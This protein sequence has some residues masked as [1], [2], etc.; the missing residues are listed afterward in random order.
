MNVTRIQSSADFQSLVGEWSSLQEHAATSIFQTWHW[1]F[2]WWKHYGAG[3]SLYL[4][5][6]RRHDGEL[7]GVLPLYLDR[8]SILPGWGVRVLRMVGTGGDTTPDYLDAIVAP[9]AD[10]PAVFASL[11]SYLREHQREWDCL[12][13]SDLAEDS[14]FASALRKWND[15]PRW[16]WKESM[17]ARISYLTLPGSWDDYLGALGR[18]RRYTIRSLRK[19]F[20]ALAG[21]RFF[22]WEAGR[23]IDAA[24]ARL[25]ALHHAR[26]E[27][28]DE[29][30]A[31]SSDAY[32]GFHLDVMRECHARGW[33]RI[34][35]ME[36]E[37]EIIAMYYCYAWRGTTYYF[38]GGFDPR[39]EKLRPGLSLMGYAIEQ[40]IGEGQQQFDM[41][42]GEYE[43]KKQWAKQERI[44]VTRSCHRPLLSTSLY[45]LRLATVPRVKRS[46]KFVLGRA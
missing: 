3:R 10:Q 42:R 35:C 14:P 28:K 25:A 6:A 21:A 30:H 5:V 1:Q 44:T 22:T 31:F 39:H 12:R 33:L 13:L 4:L 29:D 41:L 40:A 26:W 34:H 38:Q 8:E 45:R 37:N 46:I 23:D 17:A 32:N 20:L 36:L 24:F 16:A 15:A 7:A 43:Y 27:S 2:P 19:K 11:L 18:D 9:G